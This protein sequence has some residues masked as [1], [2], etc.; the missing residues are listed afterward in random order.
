M[1]GLV[2]NSI[3]E[4][5]EVTCNVGVGVNLTNSSP[6]TCINDVIV[7]YN[8]KYSKSLPLLTYEKTLANIFNE[9]EYI[10]KRIQANDDLEF[11]YDLYYKNW[12]H[13]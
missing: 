12:L 13:R 7:A 3:M 9:I 11:L 5:D 4:S 1:G 6:T 8:K 10:F 2:I